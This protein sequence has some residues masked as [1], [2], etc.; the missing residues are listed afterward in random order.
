MKRRTSF[1]LIELLVVVAIIAVLVAMLLPAVGL[2]RERA[3]LVGCQSNLRQIVLAY[4]AYAND[5]H[6]ML[7]APQSPGSHVFWDEALSPYLRPGPISP[8]RRGVLSCPA[9]RT[10]DRDATTEKRSYGQIWYPYYTDG[11]PTA[12]PIDCWIEKYLSLAQLARDAGEE[13]LALPSDLHD[14]NNIR[15][16][17]WGSYFWW[18]NLWNGGDPGGGS[19]QGGA[20]PLGRYHQGGQNYGFMDGHVSWLDRVEAIYSGHV[21]WYAGK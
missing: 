16:S 19:F 4:L 8:G 18:G 1:T 10:P 11:T 6:G 9:D 21:V 14:S 17:G 15:G 13:K 12:N 3:R 5:Y 20:Y 2:A 7:P